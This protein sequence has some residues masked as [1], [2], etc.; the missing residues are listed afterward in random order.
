[1]WPARYSHSVRIRV[2]LVGLLAC[3]TLAG[4]ARWAPEPRPGRTLEPSI[5]ESS[6]MPTANPDNPACELLSKKDRFDL[7]GYSMDAEVPVR[8]AKGTAE[9]IWVH[10]L[11]ESARSAI[12][13]VALSGEVWALSIRPQLR[14]AMLRPTT[15]KA[16]TRKLEKVWRDLGESGGRLPAD[17]VC[18]TYL[19]LAEASGAVRNGDTVFYSTLGSMT[20]AYGLSCED[21]NMILAGY[22]EHGVGPSIALQNGV[23]RLL[24]VAKER[25]AGIFDEVEAA[26]ESDGSGETDAASPGAQADDQDA[27]DETTSPDEDESPSPEPSPTETDE[28]EDEDES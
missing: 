12:R 23:L 24:E 14:W 1:L 2:G 8:P 4:C 19:L 6:P 28:A 3:A 22:G 11:N 27:T 16:L 20:A 21:G 15:G 9:C 25:S 18:P 7:V 26:A 17:E 13:V 10:S 5:T